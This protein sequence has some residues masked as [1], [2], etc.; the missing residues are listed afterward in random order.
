MPPLSPSP[1]LLPP[2]KNKT[3]W[4]WQPRGSASPQPGLDEVAAQHPRVAPLG[5]SQ[6]QVDLALH[7]L[8]GVHRC[9]AEPAVNA[10]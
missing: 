7:L 2:A 10:C 3:P 8:V 9:Q 6:L 1:P 4:W 5:D